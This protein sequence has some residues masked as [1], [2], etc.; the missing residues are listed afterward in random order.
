M[1]VDHM[2]FSTPQGQAWRDGRE[3]KPIVRNFA[4]S[5]EW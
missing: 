4:K 2:R 5:F 1:Q 3:F